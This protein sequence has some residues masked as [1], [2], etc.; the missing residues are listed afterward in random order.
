ML[1]L[2]ILNALY[3]DYAINN[4][5]TLAE[6]KQLNY[7]NKA[8]KF[9]VVKI[10]EN[11]SIFQKIFYVLRPLKKEMEIFALT[12]NKKDMAMQLEY[13]Y[14]LDDMEMDLESRL[15]WPLIKG[16]FNDF[17][18]ETIMEYINNLNEFY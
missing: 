18:Y 10:N 4:M 12:I 11:D 1:N 14:G 7:F 16:M 15:A 17:S 2:N 6:G 9:R 8:D 13:M 3:D 5:G